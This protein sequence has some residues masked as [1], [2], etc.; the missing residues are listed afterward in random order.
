M[1]S[2]G[3]FT[4]P[5]PTTAQILGQYRRDLEAEGF[6]PDM[7]GA[8]VRQAAAEWDVMDLRVG[9]LARERPGKCGCRMCRSEAP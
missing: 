5:E 7:T 1:T 8:L 3:P 2:A 4:A 9:P 6:D